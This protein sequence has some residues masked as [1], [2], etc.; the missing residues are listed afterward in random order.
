MGRGM[1]GEG[2]GLLGHAPNCGATRDSARGHERILAGPR[3]NRKRENNNSMTVDLG[4]KRPRRMRRG[5][6]V[7]C[8]LCLPKF[9]HQEEDL[10]SSDT[11]SPE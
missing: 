4:S 3:K 5:L 10:N 7:P 9:P 2:G 8:S 6:S 11:Q 1:A